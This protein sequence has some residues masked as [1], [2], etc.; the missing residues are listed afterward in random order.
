[1]RQQGIKY[2]MGWNLVDFSLFSI[3]L[4]FEYIRFLGLEH[5]VTSR[6]EIKLFLVIIAFLKLMF[7]VR[8][9]EEYGFLVQMIC[10]CIKDLCPFIVSYLVFLYV[11]SVCFV[12]LKMELDPIVD[13]VE[14][15]TFFQ[16][17][18]L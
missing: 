16:K 6:S 9:F 1:M 8:I 13:E 15:L 12:V 3:F 14:G 2:F 17:M 11:F 10:L 18:L 5:K 4:T 7:F